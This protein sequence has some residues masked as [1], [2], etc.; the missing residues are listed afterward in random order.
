MT[1]TLDA[2]TLPPDL[3]WADEFDWT[4]IESS[5]EYAV[6]GALVVDTATRQAGRPITLEGGDDRAWLDRATLQ[7]LYALTTPADRQMVL[8]LNGVT[9]DVIF[10]PG[11]DPLSARPIFPLANPQNDLAY[12]VTL[13]LTEV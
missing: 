9:R 8:V 4:P 5:Q 7:Q 12:V 6:T 2:L 1:I 3:L 13:R 11:A 10:R